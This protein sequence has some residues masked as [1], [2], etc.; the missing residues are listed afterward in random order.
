MPTSSTLISV[1]K[2]C[3]AWC[4]TIVKPPVTKQEK[5]TILQAGFSDHF[6]QIDEN[7]YQ[8][9]AE[10]QKPCPYLKK[11]YSCEIQ[12]IKPKL[13][14]IWPVIPRYKQNKRGYIIIKCPLYFHL[15]PQDI[16]Q[17]KNE[18]AAV[19]Q[20]IVTQLWMISPEMKEKYKR[21]TYE[22]L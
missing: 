8:I 19:P 2:Q 21:F 18:A 7:I 5:D 17:A 3:N 16:Q 10:D 4:C 6:I 20:E 11:D 1:C 9:Q 12:H 13:C 15:T 22:E 14:K